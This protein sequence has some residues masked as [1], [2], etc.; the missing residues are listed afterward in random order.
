MVAWRLFLKNF[1]TLIVACNLFGNLCQGGENHLKNVPYGP[2][3]EVFS[4]LTP[5]ELFNIGTTSKD[6]DHRVIGYLLSPASKVE[7]A[8]N[9]RNFVI[10]QNQANHSVNPFISA[11]QYLAMTSPKP[12]VKVFG[13]R[14]MLKKNPIKFMKLALKS[15]LVATNAKN[16][17]LTT[18]YQ[19]TFQIDQLIRSLPSYST[20]SQKLANIYIELS[21]WEHIKDQV[22]N[23]IR[24]QVRN[25]VWF[26]I[27]AQIHDQTW[28]LVWDGVQELVSTKMGHSSWNQVWRQA[29]SLNTAQI[30]SQI[31]IQLEPEIKSLID[32]ELNNNLPYFQLAQAY[33]EGCLFAELG[34]MID[35]TFIAYQL[36]SLKLRTSQAH[37]NQVMDLSVLISSRISDS[38]IIETIRDLEI[39]RGHKSDLVNKQLEMIH[40]SL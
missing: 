30:W 24:N 36:G 18:F 6:F 29:I 15:A 13:A 9:F 21:L 35:Y 39:T 12:I 14:D 22:W 2:D 23:Q 32:K 34:P 11:D 10:L 26:E 16:I 20:P 25:Q 5:A 38:D 37:Y 27:E 33:Q 28:N 3:S 1:I 31:D 8:L 4:Y 7:R 40:S 19:K 17:D